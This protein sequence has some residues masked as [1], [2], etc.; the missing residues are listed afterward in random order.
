M[1]VRCSPGVWRAEHTL[2]FVA[3][4]LPSC[5]EQ[6]VTISGTAPLIDAAK[7]FNSRPISL[8]I[9]CNL[10]GLMAGIITKTDVVRQISTCQG[11][12]CTTRASSVMTRDVTFC[13]PDVL[14]KDA[15]SKMK[16]YGL[17]H[18]PIADRT[19]RPIGVL[20]ARQAV[21]ALITEVESEE[22]LLKDYV[23][24]IGYR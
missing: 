22:E 11:T 1:G 23:E 10:D 6:L 20:N 15:W 14:L 13:H 9:V 3:Q 4:L 8:V 19:L 16:E 7:L 5:R 24:G 21:Q 2:M 12:S 18:I 17:K